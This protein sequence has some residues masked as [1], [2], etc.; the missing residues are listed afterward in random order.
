[1]LDV[2]RIAPGHR[3]LV[4]GTGIRQ[5][6][7]TIRTAAQY[8]GRHL[9]TFLSLAPPVADDA[10]ASSPARAVLFHDFDVDLVAEEAR[11]V[12][13]DEPAA[14]VEADEY[15][16]DV[17]YEEEEEDGE[18]EE[19]EE[20]EDGEYAEEEYEE[21][22]EDEEYEEEDGEE[23]EEDEDEEDED[24]E[25]EEDDAAHARPVP[26]IAWKLPAASMLVGL[27]A[28]I[29]APA[30][31]FPLESETAPTSDVVVAICA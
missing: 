30:M 18:E 23:D 29:L 28:V 12:P 21:Y 9:R 11:A 22:D 13:D 16:D 27:T 15:E 3:V 17:E 4:V 8:L 25:E 6:G 19:E 7:T 31:T 20:E 14:E 2:A 24:E 26:A 1:M 10:P 5:V